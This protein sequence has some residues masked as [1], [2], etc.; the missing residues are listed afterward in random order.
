MHESR[1]LAL[2]IESQVV[3]RAGLTFIRIE[4][5]LLVL[6]PKF[7]HRPHAADDARP[8]PAVNPEHTRPPV[9]PMIFMVP[10]ADPN[11]NSVTSSGRQTCQF[12]VKEVSMHNMYRCSKFASRLWPVAR[13]THEA[14]HA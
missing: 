1:N 6:K 12:G 7:F 3:G 5:D 8:L 4:R 2:G 14:P 9:E 10:R 11:V 13:A